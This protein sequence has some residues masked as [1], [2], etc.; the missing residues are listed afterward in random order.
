MRLLRVDVGGNFSLVEHVGNSIPRYA[1]LSHTWGEDNEEVNINDI[2]SSTGREKAGFRK[3]R[4]C[5]EQAAKDKLEY[6]WVDTCCTIQTHHRRQ[7]PTKRIAYAAEN[8]GRM[9]IAIQYKRIN[10]SILMQPESGPLLCSG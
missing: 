10:I 2:T 8:G 5:G 7:Y 6:F 3:I 4:F 1:I 9:Y